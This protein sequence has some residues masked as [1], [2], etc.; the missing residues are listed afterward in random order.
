MK[1]LAPI[2]NL[3]QHP[4]CYFAYSSTFKVFDLL[5]TAPLE[6]ISL[7]KSITCSQD[8]FCGFHMPGQCARHLQ[9]CNSRNK[10][11]IQQ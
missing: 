7:D 11:V 8:D 2:H 4:Y 6:S 10:K 5:T 3:F 1:L 9:L